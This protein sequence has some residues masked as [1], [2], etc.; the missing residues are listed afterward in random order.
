MIDIFNISNIAFSVL[1][2]DIS[3]LELIATISGLISVWFGTKNHILYWWIGLVSVIASII[4]F[5]QLQLYADMLLSVFYL[6]ITMYGLFSW[7]SQKNGV[8]VRNL[9][10]PEIALWLVFSHTFFLSFYAF[11]THLHLFFPNVESASFPLI[12]SVLSA[13][14]V[15]ATILIAKRKAEAW[16]IWIFVDFASVFLYLQKG[17]LFVAIEFGIFTLLAVQGYILWEKSIGNKQ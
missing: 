12:D 10:L 14:S 15:T 9:S 16:L 17:V 8:L 2:Y 5:F 1:G 11:A 4:I 13:L 7:R 3:Y 6:C